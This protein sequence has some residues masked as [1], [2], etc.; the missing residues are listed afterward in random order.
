MPIVPYITGASYPLYLVNCEDLSNPI[1]DI[2]NSSYIYSS[3]ILTITNPQPYFLK[4]ILKKIA[5]RKS[6]SKIYIPISSS[7]VFMG[8]KVLEM[9]K[10]SPFKSDS[11]IGL[12]YSDPAPDLSLAK[13]GIF[14]IRDL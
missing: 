2:A 11:L 1:L 13:T 4:D 6:L 7:I 9:L 5:S 14:K 12:I 3:K 10:I 8:I